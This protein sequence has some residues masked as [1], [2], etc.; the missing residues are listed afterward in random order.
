MLGTDSY[1]LENG[2]ELE[3]HI[4][5]T[6]DV[7]DIMEIQESA[8]GGKAPWSR[9]TVYNELRNPH[10]D[11]LLLSQYGEGLA[12]IALAIRKNSLHITNIA[13]KFSFQKQGLGSF[14]IEQAI[15]VAKNLDL[16]RL[17]LEVRISNQ[18]AKQLY[19]KLGF[20]DAFIKKN[21]YSD[22]GE[23]A[24]EMYYQIK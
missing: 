23:D 18:S 11:F 21:Y 20:R 24:I 17:T 10:S 15:M 8:Y 7:E 9:L 2:H 12:F 16:N 19:R 6:L 3:L 5:T 4:A 14:L 13:S 22:T 1:L